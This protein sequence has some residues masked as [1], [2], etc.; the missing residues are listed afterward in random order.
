MKRKQ[1]IIISLVA[2]LILACI[3][4]AILYFA[5][6]IFKSKR[7]N[8]ENFTTAWNFPRSNKTG[9]DSDVRG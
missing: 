3:T 5:T 7:S 1:I 8:K 2:V 4:F 6:D 9:F